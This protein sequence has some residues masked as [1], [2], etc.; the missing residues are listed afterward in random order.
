MIQ[1]IIS[2][3]YFFTRVVTLPLPMCGI[4]TRQKSEYERQFYL[5]ADMPHMKENIAN[6]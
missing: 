2:Y 4:S 1:M 6:D 3:L 5:T